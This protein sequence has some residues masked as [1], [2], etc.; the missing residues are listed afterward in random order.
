VSTTS[1]VM[2]PPSDSVVRK[3]HLLLNLGSRSY[4]GLDSQVS[5]GAEKKGL[6]K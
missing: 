2:Q 5:A 4:I 3:I 6:T 1:A